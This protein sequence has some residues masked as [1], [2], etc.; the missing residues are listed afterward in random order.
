MV[1]WTAPPW[2][3]RMVEPMDDP[4]DSLVAVERGP[5]WVDSTVAAWGQH[6]ADWTVE[7]WGKLMVEQ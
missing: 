5:S 3:A 4:T 2:V 1:D 7:S 6:L